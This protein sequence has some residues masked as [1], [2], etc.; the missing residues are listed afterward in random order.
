[1]KAID[2]MVRDVVTVGPDDDVADAI[3][4]LAEFDV[5]ALPVVEDDDKVIG[6]ISEA[7]LVRRP[8]IGTEKHRAWWLEALTPGSTLAE[9]FAK[10]HGRRVSE[11]MS[12]D[13]VSAGEDAS[14]GEIAT[15]L[16][17]H[18]IKRVPILRDGRLV[19]IVSRS[20]LIQ[21]LASTQAGNGT[22]TDGDREIREALLD[23]LDDQSWTDFGSRNVIVAGGVVHLWGLVGSAEERK[24][25]LALAEEVP[26]VTRV[27]DEMIPAY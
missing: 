27:S 1:M 11:V 19:G 4:L 6:I 21:A 2:V 13:V 25:L 17:K 3:K 20:N 8:E 15:L 5:S 22:D 9:E 10:A 23:R 7:D 26:G 16:E 12:T 24:A 14:L 18:R